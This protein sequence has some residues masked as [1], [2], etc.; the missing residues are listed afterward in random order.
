MNFLIFLLYILPLLSI[1]LSV[2]KT[3]L[4]KLPKNIHLL[5]YHHLVLLE[6]NNEKVVVDFVPLSLNK[7]D[8]IQ[9]IIG[10]SIPATIRMRK[11]PSYISDKNIVSFL[12]SS[13]NNNYD[14][15]VKSLTL[16]IFLYR[17]SNWY[18]LK[19]NN[20]TLNLYKRNCQ[21]YRYFVQQN[22]LIYNGRHFSK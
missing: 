12:C 6:D 8:I 1:K 18:D 22:Y 3:G 21:H 14:C 17:I 16:N 9:L 15:S 5:K 7:K 2:I 19:K 4:I 13:E 20:Y 11:I 10:K